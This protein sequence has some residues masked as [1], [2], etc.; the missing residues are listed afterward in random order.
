VTGTS[1]NGVGIGLSRPPSHGNNLTARHHC[2]ESR[3]VHY[4]DRYLN[5]RGQPSSQILQRIG[6]SSPSTE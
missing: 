5:V 6:L 1:Q 2:R 3:H 4:L